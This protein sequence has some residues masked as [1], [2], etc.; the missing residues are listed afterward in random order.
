MSIGPGE[1]LVFYLDD[2]GTQGPLHANFQLSRSGETISLVD[3]DGK[4]IIDS[5]TFGTQ[6]VD[7]S[8]GRY[9]DGA[10]TWGFHQSPT[11]GSANSPH[12]P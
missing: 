8:Y 7:V 11:P 3:A 5:I 2:D 1:F 9:E 12:D 10:E 4:T 6:A